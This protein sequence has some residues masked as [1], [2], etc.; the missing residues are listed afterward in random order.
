VVVG[1]RKTIRE[2]REKVKDSPELVMLLDSLEKS[3]EKLEKEGLDPQIEI[4]EGNGTTLTLSLNIEKFIKEAKKTSE[5]VIEAI[6]VNIPIPP[7]IRE[8]NGHRVLMVRLPEPTLQ[9]LVK[10]EVFMKKLEQVGSIIKDRIV[11]D[12]TELEMK[13]IEKGVM[14]I[15]QSVE[16]ALI[17]KDLL[18]AI[19][20]PERRVEWKSSTEIKGKRLLISLKIL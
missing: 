15:Q 17:M 9:E 1:W 4:T 2:F 12:L 14:Q 18:E 10:N 16:Q 13:V 19:A 6:R 3:L 8:V 5:K 20:E 11:I 7:T